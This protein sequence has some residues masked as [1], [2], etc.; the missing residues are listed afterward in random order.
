MLINRCRWDT[1]DPITNNFAC[2]NPD[3][4]KFSM[5]KTHACSNVAI[6]CSKW[7]TYNPISVVCFEDVLPFFKIKPFSVIV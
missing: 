2:V 1:K 7:E 5:I 3:S 4:P 6:G